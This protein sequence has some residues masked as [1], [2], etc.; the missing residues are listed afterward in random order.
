[1]K[2]AFDRVEWQYL[3][4]VL[5]KF[6]FGPKFISWIR[7]L[8]SAPL[9]SVK[10]NSDISPTFP[11]T[12]GTRQGCPLS[13][14]LFALA[15]EPLSISLKSSTLFSGINRGGIEHKVALY[16]DD[17]LLFLQD[18][19]NCAESLVGHLNDFGAFSGYK[20]NIA[21]SV[22]FPVNL[23][24]KSISPGVLPFHFSPNNFKYL[25]IIVSHS[26]SSLHKDNYTTLL[27]KI[28][29]DLQRWN[30]LPLSLVGRIET[31]KMN[32]LPRLLFLFQTLPLFLPKSF[33]NS[34][35]KILSSFMWA[36]KTPRITKVTLQRQK[37]DGGLASPN[38]LHYYWA[39]NILMLKKWCHSPE[40]IWCSMEANSCPRSS[41]PALLFAPLPTSYS[42]YTNNPVVLSS[43][44]IWSQF[45]QHFQ[46]KS[47][48]VLMPICKNHLFPPSTMDLTYSKWK[49]KGLISFSDLYSN[50]L[51][52]SLGGL[53]TKLDNQHISFFRFFSIAQLCKHLF[54]TISKLT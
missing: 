21:K 4:L 23:P 53:S 42:Q 26:L 33:F 2:K 15:I 35:D 30:K 47:P 22:C 13:P 49:E 38:M 52:S 48:S 51:F 43:L 34:L 27:E 8:Y 28:K 3:F 10:T 17:L 45:R 50:G 31:I 44:K 14:L 37:E 54:S 19:L 25:G 41:L 46:I 16:A 7:L 36:N 6:G 11:L 9:A 32:I 29:L 18:P 39:A 1:M 12:R 40:I 24:A 5:Q 20:L